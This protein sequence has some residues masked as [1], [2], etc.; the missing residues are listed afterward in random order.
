MPTEAEFNEV[1]R[2]RARTDR[3]CRLATGRPSGNSSQFAVTEREV[4]RGIAEEEVVGQGF[5]S[6]VSNT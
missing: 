6:E 5:P 3:E 1:T 4:E 2:E